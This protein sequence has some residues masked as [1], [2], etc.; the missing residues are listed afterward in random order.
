MSESFVDPY[1]YPGTRVLR[2]KLGIKDARIL[3]GVEYRTTWTRRQ[4][5]QLDPP[6]P[7]FD[8][9]HLQGIHFQ[10]FQDLYDWAG[11]LRTVELTKATSTFHPSSLLQEAAE[12]TF[13]W[14]AGSS[15]LKSPSES[16][17]TTEGAQLLGMP[18]YMHPFREGNGDLQ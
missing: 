17:F 10:L 5:L 2:N 3:G 15:L 6:P 1:T 4:E 9:A 8:L 11:E 18:N 16:Q 13:T 7:S 12:H 14:L